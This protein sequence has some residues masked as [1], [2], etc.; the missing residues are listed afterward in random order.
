MLE[1]V[2]PLFLFFV[3]LDALQEVVAFVE[4]NH[5]RGGVGWERKSF[6]RFGDVSCVELRARRGG[7]FYVDWRGEDAD[8][9]LNFLRLFDSESDLVFFGVV[10][11]GEVESWCAGAVDPLLEEAVDIGVRGFFDGFDEVGR[12]HVFAAIDLEV[13][14]KTA[15]EGIVTELMAE[16]V[17]NP[18]AFAVG[19]VVEF[20]GL[21][22]IAAEDGL[23]VEA[24]SGEPV[25]F[26]QRS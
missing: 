25:A 17:E 22:E 2:E 23:F 5:Q 18:A 6:S 10:G 13:V 1:L 24:G 16:H 20:F 3:E 11:V 14:L 4:E 12:D 26:H 9:A 21:I 15:P 19:V 8:I 7:D